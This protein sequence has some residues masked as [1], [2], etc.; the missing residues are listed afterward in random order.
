MVGGRAAAAADSPRW[1]LFAAPTGLAGV[2]M[3]WLLAPPGRPRPVE[4]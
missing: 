1:L 2:G 3:A 4:R